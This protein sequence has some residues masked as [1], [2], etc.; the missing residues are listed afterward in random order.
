MG[1]NER[2]ERPPGK[3]AVL[4]LRAEQSPTPRDMPMPI[5]CRDEQNHFPIEHSKIK[6]SFILLIVAI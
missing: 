5:G 6:I 4:P 1:K 3:M 2:N